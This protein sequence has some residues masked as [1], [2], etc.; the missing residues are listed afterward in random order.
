MK[1]N[2]NFS[3]TGV[4]GLRPWIRMA[5]EFGEQVIRLVNSRTL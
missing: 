5:I 3:K 1:I 2:I 4:R